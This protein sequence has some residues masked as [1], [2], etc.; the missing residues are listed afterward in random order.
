MA[1]VTLTTCWV[2]LAS[3]LATAVPLDVSALSEKEA[4]FGQVR[5]YVGGRRRRVSSAGID[6][7]LAISATLVPRATMEALRSWQGQVVLF[8]DPRGRVTYGTYE[9]V[10]AT[11]YMTVDFIDTS[12]TLTEVTV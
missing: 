1:S 7:Q 6:R 9:D 2:H 8:R 5:T 4:T 3:D 10:P 12:L 11:E